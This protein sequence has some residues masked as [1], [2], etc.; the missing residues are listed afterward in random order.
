MKVSSIS[1][2]A[3]TK[4]SSKIQNWAAKV[5]GEVHLI[6]DKTDDFFDHTD[7]L[8]IFNQNQDLNQDILE[9]K[10]RFDKQQKPV[11]KIDIN[12]T[13]QVGITNFDL[14]LDSTKAKNLLV[15][16]AEELADNP[17]LER[18]LDAL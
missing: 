7:S 10:A 16:A 8:L 12:G 2:F 1:L 13:L 15:I 6:S 17:N 14:W 9:I 4:F 5:A 3:S 11:H 18:Y